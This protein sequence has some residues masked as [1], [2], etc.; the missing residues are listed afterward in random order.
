MSTDQEKLLYGDFTSDTLATILS[1]YIA[2]LPE[3]DLP[4]EGIINTT[5]FFLRALFYQ[6]P[7]DHVYRWEGDI[8]G[9]EDE[10]TTGISIVTSWPINK[11]VVE[12]RPAILIRLGPRGFDG[13]HLD[14]FK[15][16]NVPT[17]TYTQHDLIRGVLTA[18]VI[19]RHGDESRRLADWI[20]GAIRLLVKFL[21]FGRFH[22]VHPQVHWSPV[23]SAHNLVRGASENEYMQ[24]SASVRYTWGWTGR[25][26]IIQPRATLKDF[27]MTIIAYGVP[28]LDGNS[29][30]GGIVEPESF[31]QLL[32]EET[33]E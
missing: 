11:E 7:K 29:P 18:T 25:T 4:S 3:E 12:M 33:E 27:T 5:V 26:S 10:D 20:G 13:L 19:S 30:E 14:Q 2:A 15:H 23:T 24:A 31:T 21:T 22:S 16:L 28:A 1:D 32:E 9:S 6:L 17:D 8:H